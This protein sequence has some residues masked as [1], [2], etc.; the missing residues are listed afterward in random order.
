MTLP[1]RQS[2][3]NK[4]RLRLT[5]IIITAQFFSS[6]SRQKSV[7]ESNELCNGNILKWY[8]DQLI[9]ETVQNMYAASTRLAETM[10]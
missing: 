10:Y 7:I 5:M 4:I 1:A 2:K 9:F 8:I 3:E 6:N